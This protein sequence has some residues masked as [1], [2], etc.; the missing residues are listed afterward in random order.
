M[1]LKFSLYH[2]FALTAA[3]CTVFFCCRWSTIVACVICPFLFGTIAAH[4]KKPSIQSCFYGWLSAVL[5]TSFF[6]F[7]MS[8][9]AIMSWYGHFETASKALMVFTSIG[10]SV[11]GGI[12]GPDHWIGETGGET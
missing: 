8:P 11:A 12:K 6:T 2:L 4:A 9:F 5:R 3:F 1:T 10:A 7:L